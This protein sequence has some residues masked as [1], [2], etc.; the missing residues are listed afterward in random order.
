MPLSE[1]GDVV[2]FAEI[3]RYLGRWY[4]IAT[5]LSFQQSNCYRTKAVYTLNE[6]EG[7][8]ELVNRC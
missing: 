1:A 3:K 4:E 5:T 8:V 2:E 7:Y 6:S